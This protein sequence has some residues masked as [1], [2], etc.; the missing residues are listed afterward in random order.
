VLIVFQTV[1]QGVGK[2]CE[3]SSVRSLVD[4]D[5]KKPPP[6]KYGAAGTTPV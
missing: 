1:C 4:D 2:G 6:A 5:Y 3:G